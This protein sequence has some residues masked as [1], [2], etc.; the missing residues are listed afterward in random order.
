MVLRDENKFLALNDTSDFTVW[1][2]WPNESSQRRVYFQTAQ[3]PQLQFTPA[4]LPNNK[5][6]I[7]YLPHLTQDGVYELSVQARDASGNASATQAYRIRFEVV[8]RSTITQLMNYP[9]PFSTSTRFVFTLTGSVLPEKM[10]IQILSVSGKVVRE[11][12]ESD[13][14]PI[15]IGRNITT[16]AWD[17][18]DEYGDRLGNGVYF[19]RVVTTLNGEEMERRESGADAY[20]HKGFGKIFLM[21]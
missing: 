4:S 19:Y 13:L 12:T 10:T 18:T 16:Y 3:G 1:M 15:R 20:F 17:G 9:N 7:S 21:R 11:I 6:T 5:C 8:N 2:K 14:G